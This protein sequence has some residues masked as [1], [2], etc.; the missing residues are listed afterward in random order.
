MYLHSSRLCPLMAT[1]KKIPLSWPKPG[2]P[3]QS[4]LRT[5]AQGAQLAG[6]RNNL[7]T[8]TLH[9]QVTHRVCLGFF[10]QKLRHCFHPHPSVIPYTIL[11]QIR[12]FSNF[13]TTLNV[14]LSKRIGNL[15]KADSHPTAI[16]QTNSVGIST[17]KKC[18]CYLRSTNQT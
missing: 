8:K 2:H 6:Q 17:A 7:G 15:Q 10:Q 18:Q 1:A 11:W 3:H 5:P 9:F 16:I 14:I 13:L 4:P 12:N